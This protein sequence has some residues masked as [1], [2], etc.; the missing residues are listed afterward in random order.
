M[1]SSPFEQLD[2]VEILK[3]IPHRYP[4]VM[5]D[6]VI[7]SVTGVNLKALKN[8]TINEPFFQGHFP[9]QPIMPGVLIL[10]GLAQTGALMAF[11]SEPESIGEKL[12][13]F[14]G[15]DKVRFRQKVVPGDQLIYEV[16]T[17]KRKLSLW[18]LDAKAYVDGKLV[19][20]GKLIASFQ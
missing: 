8:V 13:Y 14:A 7:D 4:S 11:L 5:V 6:R 15:M 19:A 20:E 2:I 10:E 16:K 1:D 9:E 17:I 18:T 3:T 12:A